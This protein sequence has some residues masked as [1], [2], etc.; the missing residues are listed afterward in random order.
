MRPRAVEL[1]HRL[2]EQLV[3]AGVLDDRW[4]PGFAEVPRH[5][6]IPDTVW[7]PAVVRGRDGERPVPEN[8]LQ[9]VRRGDDPA[10]WLTHVY[11]NTHVVTQVDDGVPAGPGG[12]GLMATSSSSQP[13]VMAIMLAELDARPGHRVLEVGAGTGYNAALLAHRLGAAAVTTVDIDP[14]VVRSATAALAAAGY[15][16]VTV[17]LGDGERG[18]PP[19][20]PYDRVICTA[21]V[22]DVPPAWVR[23]T[24]PGGRIVAPWSNHLFEGAV[25]TLTVGDDGR[26]T[27]GL[28]QRVSFM[29]LRGQRPR[30]GL[31]PASV[32][33]PSVPAPSTPAPSTPAPEEA[34]AE[35]GSTGLHPDAVAVDPGALLAVSLRVP[36]CDLSRW[37][38]G[39]LRLRDHVSGSWAV[40]RPGAVAVVVEQCGPRRLWDE[41][42]AGHRWWVR[43]G[44]PD[45]AAWRVTVGPDGQDFTLAT[46]VGR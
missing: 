21:A 13:S 40:V 37:A 3:D 24:R 34:A 46:G 27:G 4:R 20:A 23:Q 39:V 38:D 17:V 26:A 36:D 15:P 16:E 29:P 9:P 11:R 35:R 5:V 28:G 32:P 33:A 25:L 6:F 14:E 8:V 45:L 12:T 22:T 30:S 1:R 18:H 10:A 19:G 43:A 41:V 44:R 42:Q 31:V 7:R 2:V